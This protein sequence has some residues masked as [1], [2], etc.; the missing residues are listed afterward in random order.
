MIKMERGVAPREKVVFKSDVRKL[1]MRT[2]KILSGANL[3]SKD[4]RADQSKYQYDEDVEKKLQELMNKLQGPQLTKSQIGLDAWS[5]VDDIPML[6]RVTKR[7]LD[8]SRERQNLPRSQEKQTKNDPSS[9]QPFKNMPPEKSNPV[10]NKRPASRVSGVAQMNSAGNVP[11][12]TNRRAAVQSNHGPRA[13][14]NYPSPMKPV[15]RLPAPPLPNLFS[16]LPQNDLIGLKYK[17]KWFAPDS[18]YKGR[19]IDLKVGEVL[20]K[21]AFATVY[22]A[23]DE[24]S[25]SSVAVKIFDKRMVK[26]GSK[27]KEVQAELDLIGKL[28]HPSVIKLRR[29]A[30]DQ[31]KV[32]IV[33]DNWGKLTFEDY[34][35]EGRLHRLELKLLFGQL[36]DGVKYLH[37]HNVFH[38][39]I[40]LTNIMVKSSKV[41]LL[42]F[43]LATNSQYAC[44]FLYCGT[45]T[46][47]APEILAKQGYQGAPVDV[48][49]LG[50]CLFRLLT[51]KYPFGGSILT[52]SRSSRS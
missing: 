29:V 30:E 9:K 14:I 28:D 42:D 46:Y 35:R 37:E 44:E 3:S 34:L 21:G 8:N 26:D 6:P 31:D 20:G 11:V 1:N 24:T 49:A 10:G 45:L 16:K 15:V 32:Y 40:K 4:Q 18:T 5:D 48:W 25:N 47:M 41:C 23:M 7:L 38:R 27:R 19:S 51:K 17:I 2:P 22:E 50:V 13:Q 12:P 36:V 33:M 39:D 52:Y 43:G